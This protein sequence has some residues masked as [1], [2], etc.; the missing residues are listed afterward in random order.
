MQ[1]ILILGNGF[2]LYHNLPT[3]YKNFITV[4]N[5]LMIRETDFTF[6]D[7]LE[8]TFKKEND[9]N[10]IKLDDILLN[11]DNIINFKEFKD[12][13]WYKYFKNVLEE[14]TWID[15]ETEIEKVLIPHP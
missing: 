9:Y 7:L 12:N 10:N 5:D 11:I 14:L 2:D 15:F 4:V 1:K 3:S 13:V 8:K 6:K